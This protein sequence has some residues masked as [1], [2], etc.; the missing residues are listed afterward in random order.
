MNVTTAN[1]TNLKGSL[2]A[3]GQYD[4]NG[5][6]IDNENLN[7]K[8]KTLTFSN[9]TDS[10]Y[11]SNNSFN[12]GTNIGFSKGA[13]DSKPNNTDTKINSTNLAFSNS[14]GYQRNKTLA[15]L[16]KG[17]IDIQDKESSDDITSLNRDTNNI[18]KT[19]INMNYGVDVDATLDHRLLTKEGQKQIAE[20]FVKTQMITNT[21]GQIVT[22]ATVGVKDFFNEVEKLNTTYETIKSKIAQDE[23]LSKLL[24]SPTYT[25]EQKNA[26]LNNLTQEVMIQ[27]GYNPVTTKLIAT[28]ETGRD[29]EQVKGYYS[30]KT[31][32][33][34]VNDLY[35]SNNYELITTSATEAQ[36]AMDAQ[37]GSTFNQSQEYRD[38]RAKYSQDFGTNVADYTNF[39][40]GY[41]GQGLLS[42]ATNSLT[43]TNQVT[44]TPSV[45][46]SKTANNNI[47]FAW[48]SKEEGDN[49]GVQGAVIGGGIEFLAQ[50]VPAIAKQYYQNG[51]SLT[52]IDY[53]QILKDVDYTDVG[54]MATVG[55]ATPVELGAINSAKNIKKSWDSY[56]KY[57][58]LADKT[59]KNLNKKARFENKANDNRNTIVKEVGIQGSIFYGKQKL[60]EI[61]DVNKGNE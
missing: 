22:N 56:K 30:L 16:G 28:T 27:L 59:T 40:L 43:N 19:M 13:K 60:Q 15:T 35:N 39:A 61:N 51:A 6:F 8:T 26:I 2:L 45:F 14:L 37:D 52:N 47:E 11:S 50:T 10:S 55:A 31:N 17:N 57:D 1:N 44:S 53:W 42:T 36:R 58:N 32:S 33:S 12:V 5:N 54:A 3:S 18:S 25:D 23:T 20:D 29:G 7:L 34:F 24:N 48:L 41:T 21:I 49:W 9:S 38:D 46:N 4:K